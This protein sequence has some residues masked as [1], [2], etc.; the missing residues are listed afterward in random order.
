MHFPS[1][2][3]EEVP[4][5]IVKAKASE[6]SQPDTEQLQLDCKPC[7]KILLV[8]KRLFYP[9]QTPQPACPW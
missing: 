6:F 1:L 8:I 5:L 7:W 3:V 4:T 2:T 9:E